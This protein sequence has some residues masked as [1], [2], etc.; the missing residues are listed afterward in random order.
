MLKH[1]IMFNQL[2]KL[3]EFPPFNS[4]TIHLFFCNNSIVPPIPFRHNH[5]VPFI[6]CS[7]KNKVNKKRKLVAS[8]KC[9]K[10]STKRA[11]YSTH[12]FWKQDLNVL[13]NF[14]DD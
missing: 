5:Y 1:K 8:Q 9:K 3:R 12:H 2:I 14:A 7:G 4:E 13:P 10:G 6:F 11:T